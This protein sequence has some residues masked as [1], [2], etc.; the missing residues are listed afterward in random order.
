MSRGRK[1]S[2]IAAHSACEVVQVL[3]LQMLLSISSKRSKGKEEN[4]KKKSHSSIGM[5][6][7]RRGRQTLQSKGHHLPGVYDVMIHLLWLRLFVVEQQMIKYTSTSSCHRTYF[8]FIE[9][10]RY[11]TVRLLGTY[12]PSPG[13]LPTT[14]YYDYL[15]YMIY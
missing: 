10:L 11:H 1:D 2:C 12:T 5:P 14:H 6:Q 15:P 9:I 7:Q 4:G 3:R 13:I 8:I